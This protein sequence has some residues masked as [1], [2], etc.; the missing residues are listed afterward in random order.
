[1]QRLLRVIVPPPPKSEALSEAA[2]R[3]SVCP[4]HPR[5]YPMHFRAMVTIEHQA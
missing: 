5:L 1:M 4:S 3:P 2:V